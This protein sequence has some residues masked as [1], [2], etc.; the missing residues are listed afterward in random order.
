MR[1]GEKWCLEEWKK[2]NLTLKRKRFSKIKK[3][4]P[5]LKMTFQKWNKKELF[6]NNIV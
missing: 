3:K 1:N 6:Y 4:P 2:I 5:F